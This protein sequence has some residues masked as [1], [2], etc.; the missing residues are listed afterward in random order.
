MTSLTIASLMFGAL[1]AATVLGMV[2]GTLL[3]ERHVGPET[4][5]TVSVSMALLGTMSALVI[6]LLVSSANSSYTQRNQDVARLSSDLVRL[7]GMLRRYGEPAD[8]ARDSLRRYAQERFR[9]LFSGTARPAAVTHAADP[10]PTPR[11]T[12]NPGYAGPVRSATLEQLEDR[13]VALHSADPR[14]AWL[15]QQATRLVADIGDER[16]TLVQ[17]NLSAIPLPFLFSVVLWLA[18]LF[19]S[20]GLFAPRNLTAAIAL[21]VCAFAVSAAIKITLDM[22]SPFGGTVHMTGAPIR[23][24]DDPLRH[25]VEA[26]DAD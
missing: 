21:C 13:V 7:D 1:C 3:P 25:A 15:G 17:Q 20:F 24:A 9:D 2:G 18:I 19:G 12:G 6:G 23:I 8:A 4:R 14:Q 22:D 16:W 26:L 11:S 10:V 5:T